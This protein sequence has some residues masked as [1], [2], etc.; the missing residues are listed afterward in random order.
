MNAF[1]YFQ[2][3]HYY[4]IMKT[5]KFFLILVVIPVYAQ[6]DTYDYSCDHIKR[7]YESIPDS[8][9]IGTPPNPFS[10]AQYE[11]F[12][13]PELCLVKFI[14]MDIYS[15]IIA[16]TQYCKLNQGSYRFN[17]GELITDW[18]SFKSGIYYLWLRARSAETYEV[19]Y[20]GEKRVIVVK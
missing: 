8:F 20:E 19:L 7:N 6:Q 9:Y 10:P 16:E 18:R 15:F 14:F 13:I 1:F 2:F 17:W 3:I 11:F 4:C 5:L 12:G